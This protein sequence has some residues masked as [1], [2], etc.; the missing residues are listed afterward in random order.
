MKYCKYLMV[1]VAVTT[2]VVMMALDV[3]DF[4]FSHLGR[5]EGIHSQRIYD[6][7]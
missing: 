1:L 3:N 5:S 7:S 2:S 4:T 6:I